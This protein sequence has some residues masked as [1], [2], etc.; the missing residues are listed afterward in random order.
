MK[1]QK[2][3]VTLVIVL[4]IILITFYIFKIKKSNLSDNLETGAYTS[5]KIYVGD[6]DKN[7]YYATIKTK[8]EGHPDGKYQFAVWLDIEGN[9]NSDGSNWNNY[10]EIG[11]FPNDVEET[12]KTNLKDIKINGKDFK[13]YIEGDTARLIYNTKEYNYDFCIDVRLTERVLYNKDGNIIENAECIITEEML[14]SK[15]I[16]DEI[17]FEIE[18]K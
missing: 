7:N 11:F 8:T 6:N 14:K 5:A 16:L 10:F 2:I 18:K 13:Y 15:A 3:I 9:K 17:Q 1:K 12:N 4:L